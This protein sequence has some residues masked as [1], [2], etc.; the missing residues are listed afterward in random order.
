M[1][2]NEVKIIAFMMSFLIF[3]SAII[4]LA[5]MIFWGKNYNHLYFFV[6]SSYLIVNFYTLK[7]I[8]NG[9]KNYIYSIIAQNAS[10]YFIM[11]KYLNKDFLIFIFFTTIF[12]FSSYWLLRNK[13]KA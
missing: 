13:S 6:A 5:Y 9:N 8:Y 3:L 2:I 11:Y 7:M 10:I 12:I 4:A 1:V